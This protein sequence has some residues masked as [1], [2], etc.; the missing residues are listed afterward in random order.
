MR[1]RLGSCKRTRNAA[2][3]GWKA[4]ASA[5]L[6]AA[7][8]TALE[9]LELEESG[10]AGI[11]QLQRRALAARHAQEHSGRRADGTIVIARGQ[12]RARSGP[13]P[14][15][16]WTRWIWQLPG[17]GHP[18]LVELAAGPGASGAQNPHLLL[19]TKVKHFSKPPPQSLFFRATLFFFF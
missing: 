5:K 12:I 17:R 8:G 9:P 16:Q 11:E 4:T 3:S 18:Q 7:A 2:R 6:P 19:H 13:D 1:L 15:P 10:L 14:G